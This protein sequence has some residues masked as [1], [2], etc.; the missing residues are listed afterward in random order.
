MQPLN[1]PIS[2]YEGD[3]FTLIINPKNSAGEPIDLTGADPYFRIAHIR[4]DNSD[5]AK[6]I[7][8]DA[9]VDTINGGPAS[10]V[11]HLPGALGDQMQNGWVYD[12]GYVKDG[13]TVTV[14]TG[15]FNVVY[16]VMPVEGA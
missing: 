13:K 6:R 11:A 7:N 14:V 15:T 12:V 3:D 4:G 16:K 1:Y 2:Y 5:P 9:I 10:I 8:G